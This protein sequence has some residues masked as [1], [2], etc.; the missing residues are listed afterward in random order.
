MK[1]NKLLFLVLI[2]L[3]VTSCGSSGSN[4]GGS[5]TPSLTLLSIAVTPI[6]PR[7]A[8]GTTE[9]FTA[10][11]TYSDST[12]RN[13]TT[14]VVWSSS[15]STAATIGNTSG[16]YGLATAV[17]T[18]SA[19]ITASSGSFS[20]STTLT[21]TSAT[22]TSLGVTPANSSIS[23]GATEQFTAMGTFS[24]NATQ[25]LTTLVSWSSSSQSIATISNTAGSK[26]L[27]TSLVT[28]TTTI[29]ANWSGVSGSTLLTVTPSNVL[30]ITV[31]G[32]LCSTGSYP[33]KPCVSVTICSPDTS[34]CQTINDI[35]LDTGSS[36]LRI[37]KSLLTSISLTQV[38]SGSGS[39]AECI[40][41]A[42]GSADWGP[43]QTADVVL[44][45]EP[46]VTIPIQVIDST[47]SI[48]PHSC[49]NPDITPEAS[50]FNGI[51]GVGL[52]TED[53]GSDCASIANNGMYYACSGSTCVATTAP[54]SSQAQNP[55]SHLPVDNN[56]M[57]LQLP[58]V[59]LGGMTSVNGSLILGIGTQSNN[60]PFGVTMYPANS[61]GEFTTVFNSKT[62][63]QSFID[64]GS[65]GLFF[66]VSSISTLPTCTSAGLSQGWFCPS[67]TQNLSATNKGY[68][69]SPSGA[70]SFQIGNTSSLF[71]SSNNVFIELGAP[72]PGTSFIWGLP[73]FLGRSV[74]VGIEGKTS[75]LGTGPYWAY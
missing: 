42:D 7:I 9:Q 61:S 47:F 22:I 69:G 21:V 34:T 31:N 29:T 37:F 28:G 8:P 55:V 64:I 67:S 60:T 4:N 17:A 43:I 63:S 56:G 23:A 48:V 3:L 57:I 54:L 14:S 32:S 50:G 68:A 62:Y 51:L 25:V 49:G 45:N 1:S 6:N 75:S 12:T 30:T 20:G 65:N 39:L 11:G 52:F 41:Y 66:D 19:T 38:I 73:F 2:L 15:I 35:L 26:G 71:N 27:V 74:Y 70:V 36:G 58:S 10:T 44:G 18:G 53:C 13:I 40:Q 16:T 72:S 46:A 33:N 5:G 24:D 59:P